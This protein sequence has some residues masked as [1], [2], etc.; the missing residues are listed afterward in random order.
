MCC[1]EMLSCLV[2]MITC[3]VSLHAQTPTF[4]PDFNSQGVK[5]ANGSALANNVVRV[6]GSIQASSNSAYWISSSAPVPI[7]FLNGGVSYI[8]GAVASNNRVR[9]RNGNDTYRENV[10]DENG[11][12]LYA[13]TGN[14]NDRVQTMELPYSALTS[15][16]WAGVRSIISK[17]GVDGTGI[18]FLQ[19]WVYGDGI[20]KWLVFDFGTISEDSA[21]EGM[22]LLR[23]GHNPNLISIDCAASWQYRSMDEEGYSVNPG[24]GDTGL[25]TYYMPGL[26][27]A[28]GVYSNAI[29]Q[30][31]T[32]LLGE[33]PSQEGENNNEFDTKDINGNGYIDT[34]NQYL[35]YGVK[36]GWSGWRLVK[37]PINS[38]ATE[39]LFTTTDG[40]TC[41]FHNQGGFG[42]GS[43]SSVIHATRLWMTGS[44]ATP[45]AGNILVESIQLS[46]PMTQALS[47]NLGVVLAPVPVHRGEDICLYL[48]TPITGSHWDVFNVM[49]VLL[50][51]IDFSNPY[52]DCWN[53]AGFTPGVY[54]V[55]LKLSHPDGTETKTWKKIVVVP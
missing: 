19:S 35:S 46:R 55:R 24:C 27:L 32:G 13:I 7:P 44:T 31:I 5:S 8:A 16:T 28:A 15:T 9:F 43:N 21:D 22:M 39:G 2:L 45:V 1:K 26:Y 49:G 3:V 52:S 40:L 54:Y 23:P 11:G 30:G 38:S 48:D 42:T 34:T 53:T 51:R 29:P 37:I 41:F 36:A 20:D 12:H 6:N 18:Q 50:K 33:T 4:T 14:V 10:S 47:N 25:L 17:D